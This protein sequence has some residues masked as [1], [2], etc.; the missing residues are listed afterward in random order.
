MDAL[1]QRLIRVSGEGIRREH[2]ELRRGEA[3]PVK[4]DYRV[5]EKWMT[6]GEAFRAVCATCVPE[7]LPS[8][9]RTQVAHTARNISTRCAS[10]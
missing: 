5:V 1:E 2:G 8:M 7:R 4:A 10:R 9:C 3:G 6:P